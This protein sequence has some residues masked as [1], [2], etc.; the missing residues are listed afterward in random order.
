MSSVVDEAMKAYEIV[1]KD[2]LATYYKKSKR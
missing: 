1:A 2:G